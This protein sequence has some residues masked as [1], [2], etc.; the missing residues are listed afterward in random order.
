MKTAK[1]KS[2]ST[3]Q[4]QDNFKAIYLFP[5]EHGE[6]WVGSTPGEKQGGLHNPT[7]SKTPPTSGWHYWNGKSWQDDPTLT[8][9]PGSLPPMARQFTVT[10]TGSA[11]AEYPSYL[12]VFKRTERWWLGR[13]VYTNTQGRLLHHGARHNDW[14]IGDKLGYRALSLS[15]SQ[16]RHSLDIP[17]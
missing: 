2:S 13:P 8:V 12:G 10:A 16:S 17:D 15:G 5:D 3:E 1:M 7:P 4:S 11:A 6:W 14:L 9:T